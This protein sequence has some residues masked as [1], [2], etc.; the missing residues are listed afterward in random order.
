MAR[1]GGHPWLLRVVVQRWKALKTAGAP[2]VSEE[3][4][5]DV[6]AEEEAGLGKLAGH[7]LELGERLR[8]DA[9][10][11]DAVCR[12]LDDPKAAVLSPHLF[13]RLRRAGVVQAAKGG[14]YRVRF[15]LYDAYLRGRWRPSLGAGR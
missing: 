7:L 13:E 2:E 10:L 3:R 1:V 6:I 11:V 9:A 14:G 8:Q 12:V 5:E 15:P 4:L